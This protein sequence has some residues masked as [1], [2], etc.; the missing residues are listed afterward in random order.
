MPTKPLR[1]KVCATEVGDFLHKGLRHVRGP[2][3][4]SHHNPPGAFVLSLSPQ[5]SKR[6][7]KPSLEQPHEKNG[8]VLLQN[9][10]SAALGTQGPWKL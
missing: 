2:R 7:A 10:A 5:A 9:V 8:P 6:R 1:Q 4:I 3:H